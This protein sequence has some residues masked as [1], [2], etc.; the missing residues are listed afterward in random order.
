MEIEPESFL[1]S[2]YAHQA[3][4]SGSLHDLE[5]A[6]A[7]R[8]GAPDPEGCLRRPLGPPRCRRGRC[9]PH[10]R[11]QDERRPTLEGDRRPNR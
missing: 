10:R 8:C 2:Y 5:A 6:L 11:P 3:S 1:T 9:V 4:A 7:A